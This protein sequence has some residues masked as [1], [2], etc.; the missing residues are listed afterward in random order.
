MAP[1]HRCS[2]SEE[3]LSEEPIGGGVP[4]VVDV[5]RVAPWWMCGGDGWRVLCPGSVC[6][7]GRCSPPVADRTQ[8]WGWSN[9][10][11]L[12]MQRFRLGGCGR[13]QSDRELS[14]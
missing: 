6:A 8:S 3:G 1:C 11:L 5:S 10:M 13:E 2:R 14:T 9:C 4:D 12:R 7:H